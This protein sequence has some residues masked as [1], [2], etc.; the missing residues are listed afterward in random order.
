[1][2][3]VFAGFLLLGMVTAAAFAEI[4]V[5]GF[6]TGVI[7]PY[8]TQDGESTV[9]NGPGWTGFGPQLVLSV[10]GANPTGKAGYMF[11][12]MTSLPAIRGSYTGS[13]VN[14]GEE[15]Y[16]WLKPFGDFLTFKVGG[17]NDN[18]LAGGTYYSA[19]FDAATLTTVGEESLFLGYTPRVDGGVA[20]RK[21]GALLTLVPITNLFIGALFHLNRN[22]FDFGLDKESAADYYI[23]GQ[24]ALGYTF[25]NIGQIKAQYIGGDSYIDHYDIGTKLLQAGF[26]LTMLPTGPIEA[27]VTIPLSYS[28]DKADGY[29]DPVTIV[30]ASDLSFGEFGLKAYLSGSFG[31][32]TA[33]NVK[34]GVL[35]IA[36]LEPRYAVTET[37]SFFVPVAI[38]FQGA[39]DNNGTDGKDDA[40]YLDVGAAVRLD[41]GASWSL[42]FGAV[43]AAPISQGDAVAETEKKAKAAKFGI[44]IYFSGALF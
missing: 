16:I 7:M 18:T 25:D 4:T 27:G 6:A 33:K 12:L 28:D 41:L 24:Y 42:S 3:K 14:P 23:D 37:I 36:G 13:P 44:P 31:G 39:T 8:Y 21:P 40:S 10:A 17:F 26:K 32:A 30:A 2:K 9:A 1:M 5:T 29:A 34:T 35:I 43:Y 15:N 38:T 20:T 19:L 22:G 11:S